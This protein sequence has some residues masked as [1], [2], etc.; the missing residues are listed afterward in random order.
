MKAIK[1]KHLRLEDRIA[2]ET[3]LNYGISVSKIALRIKKDRT[4]ISKEI[5]RWKYHVGSGKEEGLFS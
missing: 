5:K 2:I 1:Y 3:Y 4:T